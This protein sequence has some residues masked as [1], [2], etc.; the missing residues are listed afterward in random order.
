[1]KRTPEGGRVAVKRLYTKVAG[2]NQLFIKYKLRGPRH[3]WSQE[4]GNSCVT[5]VM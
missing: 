3:E 4:V 5:D 2:M 1:M